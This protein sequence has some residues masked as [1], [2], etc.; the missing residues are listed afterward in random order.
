MYMV[1]GN[2]ERMNEARK[3][4]SVEKTQ[5][6]VC[7]FQPNVKVIKEDTKRIPWGARAYALDFDEDARRILAEKS[8]KMIKYGDV[9]EFKKENSV[10]TAEGVLIILLEKSKTKISDKRVLVVG[11]GA[12]G[13]E[14]VD[15]L[16]RLN[17]KVSVMTSR[18]DSVK[19][20]ANALPYG[21]S[22]EEF[23]F[24]VNTAP[25][26]IIDEARL[27][28]MKPD[29]EIVDIASPPYGFD[30]NLM[31]E[32]SIKYGVYPALPVKNR[33]E[34]AGQIIAKIVTEGKL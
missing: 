11:N 23:D 29:A 26:R 32:L 24:I 15:I 27:T 13:K 19:K 14:I 16:L 20:G 1:F 2:D 3:L 30:K 12:S 22:I 5:D 6:V 17:V 10:L 34:S 8:V 28:K 33:S 18:A 9:E 25:A 21:E 7:V 4:L 31:A